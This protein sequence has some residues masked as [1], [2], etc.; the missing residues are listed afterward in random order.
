MNFSIP[1]AS[2][3]QTWPIDDLIQSL[4]GGSY[5]GHAKY[6]GVSWSEIPRIDIASNPALRALALEINNLELSA[7]DRVLASQA[8]LTRLADD[9]WP[10]RCGCDGMTLRGFVEDHRG[11]IVADLEAM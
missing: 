5:L 7:C 1:S 2:D 6:E 4:G 9:F 10:S 11:W 3:V 8:D